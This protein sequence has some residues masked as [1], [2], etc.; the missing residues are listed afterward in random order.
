MAGTPIAAAAAAAAAVTD[1][2][3]RNAL[4]RTD[5]VAQA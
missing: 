1:V 5:Y 2:Y 4:R 3:M